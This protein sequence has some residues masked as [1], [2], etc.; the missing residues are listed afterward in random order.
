VG[1]GQVIE[2]WDEGLVGM[3]TGGKRKLTIPASMAY[4]NQAVGG[5]PA[6]SPLIFEIDLVKIN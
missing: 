5:I 6:N 4:G 3:K 1:G 2:G